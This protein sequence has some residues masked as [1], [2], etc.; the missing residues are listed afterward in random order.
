MSAYL[1]VLSYSIGP[2]FTVTNGSPLP[3]SGNFL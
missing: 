3:E 1:L 2:D